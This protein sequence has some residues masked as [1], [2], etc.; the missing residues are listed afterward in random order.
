M[1]LYSKKE[2]KI[3]SEYSSNNNGVQPGSFYR[4]CDGRFREYLISL[5]KLSMISI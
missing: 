3:K 5:F 2:V 1:K 4:H